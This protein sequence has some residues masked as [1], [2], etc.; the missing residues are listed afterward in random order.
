MHPLRRALPVLAPALL[1][2]LAACDRT[3]APP[4]VTRTELVA[5]ETPPPD[6]PEQLACDDIGGKV[7]LALTIGAEGSPTSVRLVQS[8]NVPELDRAAQ[9]GVRRWRFRPATIGGKPVESKLQ[10]PVTFTPPVERPQS[11]FVL[12]EQRRRE[13]G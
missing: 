6:Y 4:P 5:V 9:E 3:P 11:C 8:S 13:G 7:V 1:A 2:A 12:D 10:V